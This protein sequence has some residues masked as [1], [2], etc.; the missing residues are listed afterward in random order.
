MRYLI[1]LITLIFPLAIS[2]EDKI[3]ILHDYCV[4]VRNSYINDNID[5]LENAIS[6]YYPA[7]NKNK[8][9]FYYNGVEL[10]LSTWDDNIQIKGKIIN[11]SSEPNQYFDPSSVDLYIAHV[12]GDIII[13]DIP[14]LRAA[15]FDFL[16]KNLTL[17]AHS[18]IEIKA[19]CL[20]NCNLLLVSNSLD[21]VN[22][23]I[24]CPYNKYSDEVTLNNS[25]PAVI[26]SW[27]SDRETT[28]TVN[29]ENVSDKPICLFMAKD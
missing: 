6:G 21:K 23:S 16:Y 12:K 27:D 18:K 25:N 5:D 24:K 28:F 26:F 17:G 8:A 7:T 4:D 9:E 20:G 10:D 14:L 19:S 3:R 2:A 29:V 11:N 1:L 22:V 13:N 15:P